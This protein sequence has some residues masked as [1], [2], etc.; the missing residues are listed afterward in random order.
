MSPNV[1]FQETDAQRR[2]EAVPL[3]HLSIELG[4]LY[5]EDFGP[6]NDQLHRHFERVALWTGMIRRDCETRLPR[7][8]RARVSTCF[9]IDDYFNRFGS[10]REVIQVLRD[11]ADAHKLTIDYI[12]REAGCAAAEGIPL[13]RL[14][15]NRL[16]ADPPPNTTGGRPPATES[17][18]LCNGERTP[19]GGTAPAM[20]PPPKWA[21]PAENGA[22]PHSIFGDIQLWSEDGDRRLWSC[23]FLACVWQL[24]RLG[25]L[26]HEGEVAVRPYRLDLDSYDFPE[27]WDELPAIMQ[28]NDRA[29]PFS[30]YR[31]MSTLHV[32]FLPVEFAVRT[33]LSQ[34]SIDPGVAEQLAKR[35]RDEGI[36]LPDE[37]INR[38]G[39]MF[40]NG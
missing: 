21:P 4:H 17:G 24:A 15:E 29:A 34:V 27:D 6:G 33:I 31:T 18:W 39:Y 16:V 23:S 35:S 37:L 3:S 1:V 7:G 30:A 20:K 14:V 40:M 11:T 28:I 32:K 13:A 5:A 10:P 8:A 36:E 9:L 25:L 38:I 2:T 26:R 19:G 12:A 22:S